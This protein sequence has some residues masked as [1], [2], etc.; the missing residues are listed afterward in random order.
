MLFLVAVGG[1]EDVGAVGAGGPVDANVGGSERADFTGEVDGVAVGGVKR[2][3]GPAGA[4]GDGAGV[5]DDEVVCG[6]ELFGGE[7][8]G[9]P[10]VCAGCG[11]GDG[12]VDGVA[13]GGVSE[14]GDCV[15][16]GFLSL[17]TP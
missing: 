9:V 2:D 14:D 4:E 5:G 1:D 12:E 3:G 6:E 11:D 10:F 13:F 7:P 8:V 16:A 17:G 15:H